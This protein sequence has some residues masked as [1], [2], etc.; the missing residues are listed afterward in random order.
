MNDVTATLTF[1]A[2]TRTDIYL[3][4]GLCAVLWLLIKACRLHLPD[5]AILQAYATIAN[6]KGGIIL[7]LLMLWVGTLLLTLGFGIWVISKGVDPQ[8]AVVVTL[9]GMLYSGAFGG[10]TGALFKTMTG[11]DPKPPGTV[12][13]KS[14][15][16]SSTVPDQKDLTP[17]VPPQP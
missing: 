14:E 9:L 13:T 10:V 6:T 17:I 1:P 11:E 5:P 12:S 7:S 2:I 15:T 8:H 3:A 4:I 16:S